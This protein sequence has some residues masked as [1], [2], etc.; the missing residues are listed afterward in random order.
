[1]AITKNKGRVHQDAI[2]VFLALIALLLINYKNR[3][4]LPWGAI[5]D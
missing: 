4:Q 2:R 1:M 5:K 3:Y